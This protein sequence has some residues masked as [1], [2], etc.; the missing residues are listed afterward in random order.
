MHFLLFSKLPFEVIDPVGLIECYCFQ[1]NFYANYDAIDNVRKRKL[2][3]VNNIG[4]RIPT[5][6]L[7]ECN[8]IIEATKRLQIFSFDIDKFLGK[9]DKDIEIHVSMLD[10]EVLQKLTLL[11]GI[12]LSTATKILHTLYPSIIPII[13]NTLQKKYKDEVNYQWMYNEYFQIL[14]DYFKNLKLETNWTN[15]CQV[16]DVLSKNGLVLNKIRI[17]DIIWWSYLR[18]KNPIQGKIVNWSSIK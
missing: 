4:A 5:T 9:Q 11:N 10:K 6:L 16:Y 8:K 3:D 13:D 2:E 15:I 18:S 12:R 1:T 17:F 14:S 7:P